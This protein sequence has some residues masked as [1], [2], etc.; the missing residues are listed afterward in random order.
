MKGDQKTLKYEKLTKRN[1]PR[2]KFREGM[3]NK[4]GKFGFLNIRIQDELLLQ[5]QKKC[6][7]VGSDK[8][9][10]ARCL[11]AMFVEGIITLEDMK[12][13]IIN[14]ETNICTIRKE[15]TFN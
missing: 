11:M 1:D 7:Q 6:M 14:D 13:Y 10:I 4:K 15:R 9:K 2:I 12:G 8:S 3:E 5:F